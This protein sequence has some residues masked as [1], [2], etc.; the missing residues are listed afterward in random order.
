M[1]KDQYLIDKYANSEI[2][3]LISNYIIEYRL[4]YSIYKS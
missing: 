1:K 3:D 2:K 4:L